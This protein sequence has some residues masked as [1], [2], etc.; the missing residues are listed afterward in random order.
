MYFFPFSQLI[1]L[2]EDKSQ[3]KQEEAS[4]FSR[5]RDSGDWLYSIWRFMSFSVMRGYSA[6]QQNS[7]SFDPS[8]SPPCHSWE[9]T[10]SR[11][12]STQTPAQQSYIWSVKTIRGCDPKAIWNSNGI[13]ICIGHYCK[14]QMKKKYNLKASGWVYLWETFW[15]L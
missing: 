6:S 11:T 7:L 14:W 12:K 9:K 1:N 2:E 4:C 15:E 10:L 8:A 13:W 3:V 5:Q